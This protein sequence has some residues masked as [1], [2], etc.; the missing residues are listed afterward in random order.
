[1]IT[2]YSKFLVEG[3]NEIPDENKN[4]NCYQ[5]AYDYFMSNC[6]KNK[7][8]KLCHGLVTGQG[9]IKGIVYNHAWCEDEL[10]NIVYDM[11]MPD[12]AQHLPIDFYYKLGKINPDTVFKYDLDQVRNKIIEF[13][14]YGPWEDILLNNEY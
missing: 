7:S 12:W 4:G 8:L 11:T 13:K 10:H 3:I 1:M 2:K 5:Q 9:T 14:T 6:F